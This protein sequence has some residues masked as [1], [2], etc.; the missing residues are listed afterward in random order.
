MIAWLAAL[1]ISLFRFIN[2]SLA[3][4]VFDWLMPRLA[5][6]ALFIPAV[7]GAAIVFLRKAGRRG[8]LLVVFVALAVALTDGL[9]CNSIKKAVA[10]QRPGLALADTRCLLGSS[11]SGSMP[12][13]HAANWFAAT[14]VCFVFY[15]RSWRVMLP[16][17]ATV[18]F[19]RVYNG[20]HYPSD[21]LAGAILG[22]GCAGATLWGAEMLWG[23]VG[24][25]WF[26]V[27]W[28]RWPSVMECQ[29]SSAKCQVPEVSA[30]SHW[31][32]LAY[33]LIVA[34]FLFRLGYIASG[35]IELSK[36]EAY[37]WLWSKHLALSYYSKPPGI[38][39][40][41][42][43]GTSIWGDTAFGVR[44][45]SPVFAAILSF[46]I[47]RFMAREVSARAALVLLLVA[48]AAPLMGVGAILMTIDPPLVL[49]WTLSIVS[50]WHAV[51]PGGQTRHW[52]LAGT[53]AGLAFLSKYSALY[54]VPCWVLFFL[55]WKPARIHLRKPGPYLA[56]L[57]LAL[58][59]LPVIV[60]NGQHGWITAEHVADNA[61]LASKWKLSK[62]LRFSTEFLA[63][64]TGLLNPVFLVGSLWVM[65]AFWKYR[66]A[67]VP[68][69]AR[70]MAPEVSKTPSSEQRASAAAE[71]VALRA[72][73]LWRFLFC[74]GAPVFLG[75]LVYSFRSRVQ[76]NWI[77]PAVV[78][79]FCLMVAYW[80][81]RWREGARFVKGWLA[82]GLAFGFFAV[83]LL[84]EPRLLGKI[85][86]HSLPPEVEPHRRVR[87]WKQ[88]ASAVEAARHR[89]LQ[90]GKPVFIIADHYGTTGLLTFYLPEARAAVGAKPLAGPGPRADLQHQSG[91]EPL[92]YS[93][94]SDTPKNQLFFWREY[95]YRDRRLGQNA[96]YVDEVGPFALEKGWFWKWLRGEQVGYARP[97]EPTAAPL[98]L[99]QEFESVTDLGIREITLD[100]R[101]FRRV[102]VFECRN[103]LH[104][105][106]GDARDRK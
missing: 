4:P 7:L 67:A 49:C 75:H 3:N 19:S 68:A 10:R 71:T 5:G 94:G 83:A 36:D 12:S 46:V 2:Q 20:V 39:L 86:G 63:A 72:K 1:D 69:A 18:S 70:P 98:E 79:M 31:V 64:E 37:Q 23:W 44:F 16:L 53:A 73:A 26:P 27:W 92:V 6:H 65:I 51:Q 89:L 97:I 43:A 99:R 104:V 95:R 80:E 61:G 38:A 58:S 15:R 78:P 54:L 81:A 66:S 21:V 56:L 8:W 82:G 106:G 100:R 33:M 74:M 77:A 87:A 42:F 91:V 93:P 57:V 25:R 28:G 13:S 50:G 24:R 85:V 35:T 102:Q 105:A 60:W 9:V 32:R 59:T 101:V 76:P 14:L 84:Y 22:A 30:E 48:T 62:A 103:L 47:V 34:L 29:V 11:G 17:A 41:Q 55:V 90:E 45:F 52:L 88:T 96:I 40:I